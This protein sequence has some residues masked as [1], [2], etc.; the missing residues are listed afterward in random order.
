MKKLLLSMLIGVS[1]YANAQQTGTWSFA[2]GSFNDVAIMSNDGGMNITYLKKPERSQLLLSTK[3]KIDCILCS[4]DFF[5]SDKKVINA[6]VEYLNQNQNGEYV[7]SVLNKSN[8][9]K[10]FSYSQSFALRENK[11]GSVYQFT[12]PNPIRYFGGEYNEW[13]YKNEFYSTDSLNY[14]NGKEGMITASLSAHKTILGIQNIS[15]KG[16]KLDCTPGC[17]IDV[18]FSQG[19]GK[20]QLNR[21]DTSG[22]TAYKF[23]ANFV[24]DMM[25]Y[26]SKDTFAIKVKTVDRGDLIFK[27]DSSTFSS[28]YN[29]N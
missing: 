23:S 25:K 24:K 20:Y 17:V 22:K 4:V 21:E 8:I 19:T 5:F 28:S 3:K 14:Y 9:L 2:K 12:S 26:N 1:A 15:I 16:T 7:Y 10:A 29:L 11:G 13:Q 6:D 18:Y 27:F